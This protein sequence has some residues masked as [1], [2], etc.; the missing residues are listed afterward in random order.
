M[1]LREA[2]W[3]TLKCMGTLS[4]AGTATSP[5]RSKNFEAV[6]GKKPEETAVCVVVVVLVVVALLF[7]C[8]T[9]NIPPESVEIYLLICMHFSHFLIF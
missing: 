6:L 2:T 7:E 4:E 3:R 8:G 5:T 1:H 9:Y